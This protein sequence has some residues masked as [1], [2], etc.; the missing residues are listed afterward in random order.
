MKSSILKGMPMGR[1]AAQ[2]RYR[3]AR[4]RKKNY[5]TTRERNNW[6]IYPYEKLDNFSKNG[7]CP[8]Q[9]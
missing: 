7:R 1:Y 8:G 6:W 2:S 4:E 5:N 3:Q 9:L